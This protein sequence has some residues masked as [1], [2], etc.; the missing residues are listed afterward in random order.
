MNVKPQPYPPRRQR[1]STAHTYEVRYWARKFGVTA[2]QLQRAVR[3][4][5]DAVEDVRRQLGK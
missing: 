1:I 4:V 5:G 2:E 3:L